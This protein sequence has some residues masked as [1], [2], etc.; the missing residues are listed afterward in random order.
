MSRVT[1]IIC[2]RCGKK[3]MTTLD[4]PFP[5]AIEIMPT[6]DSR[7]E[8]NL[9]DE[10]MLDFGRWFSQKQK[11]DNEKFNAHKTMIGKALDA[12]HIYR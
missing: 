12:G 10:C 3:I 9:C 8:R 4:D 2:D 7:C 5:W 11:K 1:K 6:P